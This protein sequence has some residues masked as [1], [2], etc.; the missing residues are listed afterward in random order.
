MEAVQPAQKLCGVVDK[1]LQNMYSLLH[2]DSYVV[3]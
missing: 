1:C 3:S 2:P